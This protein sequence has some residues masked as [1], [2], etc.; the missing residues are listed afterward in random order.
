MK[1]D[2]DQVVDRRHTNSVK[3]DVAD[4]IFQ[5]EDLLPLWIAD[6]DFPTAPAIQAELRKRVEQGIF[7]YGILPPAYYQAVINWMKRRHQCE[8]QREQIVYAAGVVS[9]LYYAIEAVTQ[10]GDEVLVN[11]PVYHPFY[12]AVEGQGRVLVKSPLREENLHYTFDFEDMERRVT[13]R[14]RALL[15]CSPHNP[16][17]RVWKREE[18]EELAA[19]CLRHNLVVI[20]DEIHH[21]LTFAAHTVFLNVSPEMAQRTILCTAPSKTFNLA[22]IQASNIIIPS[23]ELRQNYKAAAARAHAPSA[24][25]FAAPAVIGAYDHSEEWLDQLLGY[26]EGNMDLFCAVIAEELPRLRARKPEGTYLAWVD[27]SGL[28]L[29]PEELKRFFVEKCGLAL[30]GGGTFGEE[31]RY[32]ARFNLA[33]PRSTVE[34]CLRRLKAGC[35]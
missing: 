3:W 29:E 9:A 23:E 24:H 35:R 27:C 18:M 1:F 30:S 34:E 32:F 22:G 19:F 13:P 21:D 25:S 28:G 8:V 31:G 12:Q 26:L 17:G 7:G 5:G 14:T 6:M 33:C 11:T 20:A 10:P 2:F 16:V 15:L 4:R